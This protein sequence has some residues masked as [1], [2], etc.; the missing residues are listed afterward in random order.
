MHLV[1]PLLPFVDPLASRYSIRRGHIVY[2]QVCASCH[3]MNRISY[4]N[5][6]G[7]C[8]NEA[9]TKELAAAIEVRACVRHG[10]PLERELR[11]DAV[12]VAVSGWRR[13]VGH[14]MRR[15]DGACPF[16][17]SGQ[18]HEREDES[19]GCHVGGPA[20]GRL[21]EQCVLHATPVAMECSGCGRDDCRLLSAAELSSHAASAQ[22]AEEPRAAGCEEA[23]LTSRSRTGG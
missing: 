3:S 19:G 8:Y 13:G 9:E 17:M 12:D 10:V 4:R 15:M 14:G 16:A 23:P 22:R 21:Q 5:L 1:S 20:G 2:T 18:Q 11:G 7:V 6:V